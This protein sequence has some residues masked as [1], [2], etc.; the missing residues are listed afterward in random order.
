[1]INHNE[2]ITVATAKA[3]YGTQEHSD[4]KCALHRRVARLALESLT[5]VRAQLES[6]LLRSEEIAFHLQA[7]SDAENALRLAKQGL[8]DAACDIRDS[9]IGASL[10]LA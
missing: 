4:A 5:P 8:R 3:A 10:P 6:A 1:M 7:I 2:V 9:V